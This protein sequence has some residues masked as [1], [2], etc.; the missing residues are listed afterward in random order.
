MDNITFTENYT[1]M[2]IPVKLSTI[3]SMISYYNSETLRN[4]FYNKF[5]KKLNQIKNMPEIIEE[6]KRINSI[7]GCKAVLSGSTII[8]ILLDENW[9][10]DT[11]IFTN[12]NTEFE[13]KLTSIER[14]NV[15]HGNK[16]GYL[17]LLP[18]SVVSY[19]NSDY[20]KILDVV[21]MDTDSCDPNLIIRDFDLSGLKCWF[22]GTTLFVNRPYDIF[23]KTL[24]I[25][26]NINKEDVNNKRIEKYE[27]R[28]FKVIS[29]K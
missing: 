23:N 21:K 9:D 25:D 5:I 13:I 28:G 17:K 22:D 19:F 1:S 7:P 10:T 26:I 14:T 3:W 29:N 11:D 18:T 24:Y 6:I 2:D 16:Y 12:K 4:I 8:Q 27:K 15:S 20:K